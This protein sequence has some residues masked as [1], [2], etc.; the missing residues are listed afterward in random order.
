MPTI[1]PY[2]RHLLVCTGPRCDEDGRAT[3]LAGQ[4]QARL[5]E[6]GLSSGPGRVK[7]TRTQCFAVCRRG[8][9]ACLEPEGVWLHQLTPEN[10]E[11]FVDEHL[12]L[13]EPVEALVFHRGPGL[14]PTD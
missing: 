8:P 4:L 5:A 9:I 11:R 14:G 2:R 13:G 6:A 1:N 12:L 3:A 10:A 7:L